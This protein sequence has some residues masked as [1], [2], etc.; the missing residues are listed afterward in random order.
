MSERKSLAQS[1]AAFSKKFDKLEEAD[2]EFREQPLS[3]EKLLQ[4]EIIRREEEREEELRRRYSDFLEPRT[5]DIEKDEEDLLKAY[6]LYCRLDELCQAAAK[7]GSNARLRSME[8]SS[9]LCR[10]DEYTLG[11]EM[12]FLRLWFIQKNPDAK[13]VPEFTRDEKG[14]F[15]LDFTDRELWTPSGLE[16]EIL[17][18]LGGQDLN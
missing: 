15:F 7:E 6:E 14:Q 8:I 2:K 4:D 5:Q 12:A 13:H 18:A 16:K 3:K 10:R 1:I 11:E 9:P 17:R